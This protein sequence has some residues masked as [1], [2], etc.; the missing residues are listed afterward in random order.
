MN[1]E[2]TTASTS[3]TNN[4]SGWCDRNVEPLCAFRELK[5]YS[6]HLGQSWHIEFSMYVLTILQ[7]RLETLQYCNCISRS[8]RTC[9]DNSFDRFSSFI[10]LV[11]LPLASVIIKESDIGIQ[12]LSHTDCR[13]LVNLLHL[14]L[15]QS[16]TP[17]YLLG[18]RLYLFA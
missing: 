11:E 1:F 6:T 16:L 12:V 17:Q 9:H 10:V 13:I 4:V 3:P 15:R 5:K 18:I 7:Y 14:L 8:G 2:H